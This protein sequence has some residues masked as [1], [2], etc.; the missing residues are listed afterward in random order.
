M[1]WFALYV[2]NLFVGWFYTTRPLAKDVAMR[3][4]GLWPL[5]LMTLQYDREGLGWRFFTMGPR[6]D[7]PRKGWVYSDSV[8]AAAM[9]EALETGHQRYTFRVYDPVTASYILGR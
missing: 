2:N 8:A 5:D 6:P 7:S 4:A 3:G 1:S 9:K